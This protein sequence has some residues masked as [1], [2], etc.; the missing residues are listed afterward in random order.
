MESAENVPVSPPPAPAR[1]KPVAPIWHTVAFLIILL[2]FAAL[3]TLPVVQARAA[4][5]PSRI[6]T[7]ILTICFELL[8]VGYIWLFGL[9]RRK[10]SIREIIG[11]KWLRFSDFLMD[12]GIALLF[13]CVV[14]VV[15]LGFTRLLK[16][17]GESA[18]KLILPQ[19]ITELAIFVLLALTAGFCE[20]LIF[21]GYL[22]RQ[23]LALTGNTAA[24]VALQ[25]VVFGAAHLYQG[26]K[27]V[28]VISVYGAM[29][30]VL[31]VMRK[32]LRP[33]MIQHA[34]N[35]MLSGIAGYLAMKYK[36]AFMLMQVVR[37]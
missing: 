31:A 11:G 18:A 24:S 7:Y 27:G 16:F 17:N 12:V 4:V 23:F 2:G 15:L 29:F 32:S 5:V 19:T 37:R 35:D 26:A 9:R 13:W 20:E 22:Q 33:G 28:L 10:V 6:P 25:A 30:G 34:G 3:Q 1:A 14:W 21:R 8:M 36:I